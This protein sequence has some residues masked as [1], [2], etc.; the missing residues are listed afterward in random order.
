MVSAL[1]F[2]HRLRDPDFNSEKFKQVVHYFI[3]NT[4]SCDNVGKKVLFKILYFNDFNFY[5]LF[6]EKLTGE[7][8]AKLEH[9]PAPRHFNDIIKELKEEGKIEERKGTYYDK[10]QTRYIS[11]KRPDVSCLSANELEHLDS[12][13]CRY[14]EMN[15]SQIEALSHEDM[16]WKAAT[17][18]KNLDYELVFY[19]SPDMSIREYP[20]D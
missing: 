12:T 20:D 18:K 8:Y 15:G 16:P 5:E 13:I 10:P 6:E 17:M 9:G 11:L 1:K 19:R 2:L 3:Q 4:S 7:I 14:G